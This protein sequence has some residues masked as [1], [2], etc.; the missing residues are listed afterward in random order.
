[1]I[2]QDGAIGIFGEISGITG[3]IANSTAPGNFI[4]AVAIKIAASDQ[5]PGFSI[6]GAVYFPTTQT[7]VAVHGPDTDYAVGSNNFAIFVESFD[8]LADHGY[9]VNVIAVEITGT[10]K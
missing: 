7:A 2:P 4:D 1:M 9:I 5:L 3:R 8:T 10:Q 6:N